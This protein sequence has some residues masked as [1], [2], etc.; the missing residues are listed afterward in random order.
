MH[1]PGVG[2]PTKEITN[3]CFVWEVD[4]ACPDSCARE[5]HL[6]MQDPLD[7]ACPYRMLNSLVATCD[8]GWCNMTSPYPVHDSLDMMWEADM[9]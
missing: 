4:W 3:S 2:E 8:A 5:L 7:V 6:R 1:F 9:R